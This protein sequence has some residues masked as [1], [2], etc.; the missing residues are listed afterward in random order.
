MERHRNAGCWQAEKLCAQ[1]NVRPDASAPQVLRLMSLQQGC[2]QRIRLL[3]LLRESRHG[4]RHHLPRAG[5]LLE[6]GFVHKWN[7]PIVMWFIPVRPADAPNS[8]MFIYDRCGVVEGWCGAWKG[9][10]RSLGG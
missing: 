2:H 1:H 7:P 4:E 6:Q 9:I 8:A 10:M 5:F 3:D